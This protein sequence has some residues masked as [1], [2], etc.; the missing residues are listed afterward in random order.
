MIKV[1]EIMNRFRRQ[2][3]AA[4]STHEARPSV[5]PE[6]KI[7]LAPDEIIHLQ[8]ADLLKRPCVW[9]VENKID[10]RRDRKLSHS[11][12]RFLR[13]AEVGC[14]RCLLWWAGV[15]KLM[16][17]KGVCF[18]DTKKFFVHLQNVDFDYFRLRFFTKFDQS[19]CSNPMVGTHRTLD[20]TRRSRVDGIVVEWLRECV[21]KHDC[22]GSTA[23]PHRVL[24]L[25]QASEG[26]ISL[27]VT[28]GEIEPYAALSHCWGGEVPMKTTTLNY[29]T[30]QNHIALDDLPP[31]F[32]DAIEVTRT[33]GLQYLWIDAL[34][35]IQDDLSDWEVESRE[36][37]SIYGDAHLVIGADGA[38]GAQEG[39]LRD[40][41]EYNSLHADEMSALVAVVDDEQADVYV[42]ECPEHYDTCSLLNMA[43]VSEQYQ[44]VIENPLSQRAWAFQEQL[45]AR[46]MVHFTKEE[47]VW[48]CRSRY[49]CE[50]T[51]FDDF[52]QRTFRDD[53]ISG[54]TATMGIQWYSFVNEVCGRQLT[55]QTDI[56]PCLSGIA[57][58][59]EASMMGRYL[60]GLWEE[61]LLLGLTWSYKQLQTRISPQQAP[62]WSWAS[63]EGRSSPYWLLRQEWGSLALKIPYAQILDAQC[64]PQG[65]NAYGAI[66][67]GHIEMIAPV[68]RVEIMENHNAAN[69]VNSS[70]WIMKRL[71]V[72]PA[73]EVSETE[74]QLPAD[75]DSHFSLEGHD[76]FYAV[77]IAEIACLERNYLN[78]TD[79]SETSSESSEDSSDSDPAETPRERK[80]RQG[81]SETF[82]LILRVRERRAGGQSDRF[83]RVGSFSGFA[84]WNGENPYGVH[85]KERVLGFFGE[86]RERRIVLL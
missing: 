69:E 19:P 6:Q 36:M 51:Q 79:D 2:K 54:D 28:D 26:N 72:E 70:H 11:S 64:I 32:K 25:S 80:V 85:G 68:V 49:R 48:E 58:Q 62:S 65:Q 56:L 61:D 34:C 83:E 22:Q 31:N 38:K 66:S 18:E 60:A 10:K 67:Q 9:C 74:L 15:L 1:K 76:S 53:Y 14:G 29:E 81:P 13:G 78:P 21:E 39:F 84:R 43:I 77:L 17:L 42:S 12:E 37:S 55:F 4:T 59:M 33:L 5:V 24:D 30:R 23:L 71:G 73:V 41:P 16:S 82:G 46:R 44:D 75:P 86:A 3:I 57:A 52:R 27:Y 50:C 47:M 7:V 40:L 20:G 35:I 63:L 8:S 45:L